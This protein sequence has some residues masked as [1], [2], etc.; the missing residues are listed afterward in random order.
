MAGDC[1]LS[2]AGNCSLSMTGNW[3]L[4][5]AG[6]SGIRELDEFKASTEGVEKAKYK[7]VSL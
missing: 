5:A 4:S 3:S 7:N 6:I 2:M 1:S